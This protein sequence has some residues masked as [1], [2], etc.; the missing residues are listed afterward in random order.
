M[1]V[2]QEQIIAV[3]RDANLFRKLTDEQLAE[4]AAQFELVHFNNKDVIYKQGATSDCFYL[5]MQGKVLVTV[6]V[7][8]GERQLA[9]LV[10]GDYFGEAL[11]YCDS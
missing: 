4:L 5:I 7:K 3:L 8:K 11:A 2:T 9:A 6:P 1:D 10:R